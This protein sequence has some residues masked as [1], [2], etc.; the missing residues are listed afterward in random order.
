MLVSKKPSGPLRMLFK[1]LLLNL[2]FLRFINYSKRLFDII[3]WHKTNGE[4]GRHDSH[5][6]Y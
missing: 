2:P 1:F 4:I 6:I 5:C 3:I